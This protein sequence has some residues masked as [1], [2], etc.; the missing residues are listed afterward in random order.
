MK[1]SKDSFRKFVS[2]LNN[3]DQEGGYWLPNI[4]RPFV[5]KEEQIER[6]FDSI[7][8]E[9]P[10]GTLLVWKTKSKIRRRKFIDNYKLDIKLTDFYV[11]EDDKQKMLVLDGQQRLQSLFIGLLGSYEKKELC[12]NVLSGDLVA[13]EDI[14]YKFKFIANSEIKAPWFK[15][16]DIVFSNKEYDETADL[17]KAKFDTD[18]SDVDKK[19]ITRIVAKL[20]RIFGTEEN[21]VYQ[22]VD[23]VDNSELYTEDDIVEIFIR[24]NSGGTP[25]GKSDLLFSLLTSSWDEADEQ[26]EDLLETLNKTGYNFNRDFVL[27]TCL[28]IFGKGA[29]YNV[30]KFRDI[31]TR[32]S[33][34]DNWTLIS[35]AIKDVKDF[36]YG[37]TFVKTD[38]TLP[39]Y[40]VLIPLIYFRYH[41]KDKWNSTLNIPN[42]L[43]RTLLASAFSGSPDALIDKCTKKIDETKSFDITEIFG[44]I[45]A[46]GR[47]LEISRDTV[48]N[49]Y[50][51]SKQIHLLFNLWYNFNYQ[52]TY[53]QNKP[54]V[55]HIFPQSQLKK[56]K[57]ANPETGR[58]DIL[59]YKWD[60]RD[61][62]ANCMLLTAQEN[63]S[64]GKTDILP[65]VWFADK[66][67]DYLELHL[68]PQD[69]ELWKLE[70]FEKFVEERKKLI[71][72][73]FDSIIIKN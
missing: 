38:A 46:D 52:P 36:I 20:T 17:I 37:K 71:E 15:L 49:T 18:L 31:K 16:K 47:N 68:I 19:K 51:G 39:S 13:P 57:V 70:N 6:L 5:W 4:Q 10:I 2:Y 41:H 7:L 66:S 56:I 62:I 12:L 25:L 61:Q 50:Y 54:Q 58:M 60:D 1:N 24:A 27:K 67:K 44:V 11:P 33:I 40:L 22:V 59:K 8:R 65:E 42:Y 23:S 29:A 30:E 73:K 14:R 72:A 64:G 69:K 63:G 26:M 43:L 48:L 45:K 55:D 21:L 53:N 9:Y 3:S 34:I 32:Q 35:E 28:S